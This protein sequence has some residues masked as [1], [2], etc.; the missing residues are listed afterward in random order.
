ML[1]STIARP[2][3]RP[4]S[5]AAEP[6][7]LVS[8]FELD[9]EESALSS[10]SSSLLL[11]PGVS[12]KMVSASSVALAMALRVPVAV[13][14]EA[15]EVMLYFLGSWAPQGLS[16]RQEEAQVLLPAH[17]VTHWLPHSWQTK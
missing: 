10:L 12:V 13:P 2:H 6:L 16:S 4:A 1:P 15:V 17:L 8:E 3:V 11:L 7:G 9:S 5:R 14:V